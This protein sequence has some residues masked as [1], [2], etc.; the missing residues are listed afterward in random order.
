MAIR[1][2][3]ETLRRNARLALMFAATV[4]VVMVASMALV[5]AVILV[6]ERLGAG[7]VDMERV[8]LPTFVLASILTGAVL[9]ALASR[10][11]LHPLRKAMDAVD[12]VADGDFDVRL[13]LGGAEEFRQLSDKFNYMAEELGSVEMLR[14]DFVNDFSHEL[15]TPIVSIR[16]FARMLQRDD[17]TDGEREEYLG[18]IVE[19]SERLSELSENVLALSKVEQQQIVADK[20]RFDLAEQIRLTCALLDGKW[21]G[22]GIAFA[23]A[24]DE[25]GAWGNA[26]MLAQVWVNLLDNAAKFSP[27]GG[28]V[29]V[30]VRQRAGG[31]ATVTVS[32]A[33]PLISEEA[34]AHIFD[35]FYQADVSHATPGNGL[36]LAIAKRIV[37]LHG[38]ELR[39]ARRGE[40][41]T[42]TFE[43]ALPGRDSG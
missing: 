40:D 35:K 34:S 27:A 28:E 17:L 9:A 31:A 25:C 19:E 36:G 2:R 14:N 24:G 12:A 1:G 18:I 26:E 22:K 6:L 39:L 4:F 11:P 38:G 37:E 5:L 7:G 42:V 8:P 21:Q 23:L 41:G 3:S 13:D 29:E 16:G 30:C 43:V 20:G 10:V 15:K 33:G 32:N